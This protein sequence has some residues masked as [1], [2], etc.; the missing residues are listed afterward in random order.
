M[1]DA[2]SQDGFP[3]DQQDT[4]PGRETSI[5]YIVNVILLLDDQMFEFVFGKKQ[6]SGRFKTA[7]NDGGNVCAYGVPG[8][9]G[10]FGDAWDNPDLHE[11]SESVL[12][13]GEAVAGGQHSG[14]DDGERAVR[15][16]GV[17]VDGYS[18]RLAGDQRSADFNRPGFLRVW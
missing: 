13:L 1:H 8:G 15:Y 7:Y 10:G 12:N 16:H 17:S 11:E 9:S 3:T 5:R 4:Y 2:A 18:Q 6:V 14:D